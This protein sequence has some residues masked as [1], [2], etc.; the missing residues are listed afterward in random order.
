VNDEELEALVRDVLAGFAPEA[1]LD[2]LDPDAPLQETLDLD[3]IDFLN[4][5]VAIHDRTGV[6]VPEADYPLVA[7]LGGCVRYLSQHMSPPA[8]G[9]HEPA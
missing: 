6:E 4:A 8:T 3:S 1:D 5:M 7:T 2:A 9:Q